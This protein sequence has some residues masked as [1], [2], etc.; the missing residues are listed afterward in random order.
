MA[1]FRFELRPPVRHLVCTAALVV[2]LVGAALVITSAFAHTLGRNADTID[3]AQF[4]ASASPNDPLTR[5][6]YASYLERSFDLSAIPRSLAEY[7]TA[8]ALSP[9][10]YLYWLA[11]GQARERDGDRPAAETAY[12]R[13]LD[14]APNYA[15]T[16]WALGN[17]L[18][19]QGKIDEGMDLI[20][21]AVDQDASFASPA[22]IAAMQ[23]FDGDPIRA[24]AV[25]GQSPNAAAELAKYLAN[26]GRFGEAIQVWNKIPGELRLNAL[27]EVGLSIR[28]KLLEARRYRDAATVTGAIEPIE[29]KRP[30]IATIVNGG[31][32]LEIS[33]Q[34]PDAFDWKLGKPYP[35]FGLSD[36]RPKEGRY[37]LSMRFSTPARLDFA[38]IERTVAVEPAANYEL[39][40]SYRQ[41]LQTRALFRW[42]VVTA[43]DAKRLGVTDALTNSS[44]WSNLALRFSVPDENDGVTL[45]LIREN[46]TSAVC[47]ISGSLWFDDFVLK[48]VQ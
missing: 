3:A 37:S 25:F 16:M 30:Q 24:A 2:L 10:N 40:L 45:R 11:L 18:V 35:L 34:D 41:D 9:H 48:K 26:E 14:V 23:A 20:R 44:E 27:R 38:S 47:T 1:V 32:E 17:N 15:R 39:S 21:R 31:F 33:T 19:R 29:A 28:A 7:E 6:R 4:A 12:R 8:V 36:N 43:A 22:V 5:Y 42:E 13:A 46:C